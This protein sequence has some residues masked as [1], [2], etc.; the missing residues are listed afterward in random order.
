MDAQLIVR[1]AT[2]DDLPAITALYGLNVETGAASFEYASPPAAEMSARMAAVAALK[3]PW[4]VAEVDAAFAGYGYAGP[5]RPRP[6][7]RFTVE[8]TVYV[9]PGHRGR[10]VGKAL[11][12][13]LIDRCGALGLRQMMAVIGDAADNAGSIAL[14]RACGFTPAGMIQAVGWKHDGWRDVMF[15]QRALGPG[16]DA[17]PDA[18]GLALGER[19]RG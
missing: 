9:A 15:M 14:H 18:P 8:D 16:A 6:G 5:F 1:D 19:H 13:A 11:L 12:T 2:D 17:P 4:L 10:G 3:L 7:Y